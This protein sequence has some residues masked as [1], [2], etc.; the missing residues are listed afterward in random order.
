MIVPVEFAGF[1]NVPVIFP[2]PFVPSPKNTAVV[3]TVQEYV[4]PLTDP[5]NNIGAIVPSK[6]ISCDTG[7]ARTFGTGF[8]VIVP[9]A[10]VTAGLH[11]IAT[12]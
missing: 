10:A 4:V 5:L 2:V 9:D 12:V 8:T 6:H 11:A 3:L 1:V 7:E